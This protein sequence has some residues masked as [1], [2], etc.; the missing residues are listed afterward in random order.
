MGEQIRTITRIFL[1]PNQPVM[2]QVDNNDNVAYTK[3]QLQVVGDDEVQP[4]MEGN[5]LM[6]VKEILKKLKKKNRVY[7]EI[8]WSDDTTSE[9]PR[10]QLLKEIPDMI[11]DFEKR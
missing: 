2:Y 10:T 3:L 6:E 9:E 5:R 11:K 4:S 7:Y 8:L 1:R